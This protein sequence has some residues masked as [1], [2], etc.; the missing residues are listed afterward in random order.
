MKQRIQGSLDEWK[1]LIES[2]KQMERNAK[3]RAIC[4]ECD[5]SGLGENMAVVAKGGTSRDLQKF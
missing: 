3:V 2:R 1:E 4:W 5:G